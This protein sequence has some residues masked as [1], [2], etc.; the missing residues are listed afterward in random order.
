MAVKKH[1]NGTIQIIVGGLAV[2]F[3]ASFIVYSMFFS[4]DTSS[5]KEGVKDLYELANP[6]ITAEVVSL[7]EDSGLYKIGLKVTGASGTNYIESWM[8]KDGRLL[9]QN[10]VFVKDDINQMRKTKNFVDCIY[11]KNLRIYGLLNQTISPEIAQLTSQ[12]LGIF[13]NNWPKVYSDCQS[14]LQACLNVSQTFPFIVFNNQLLQGV[15]DIPTLENIT[16]CKL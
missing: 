5:L 7:T 16:G 10:M 11:G 14:N 15:K 13:G 2:L 8:T 6:G 4:V 3:I 12:Q 1:E 9:T